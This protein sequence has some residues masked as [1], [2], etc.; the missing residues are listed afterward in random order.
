MAAADQQTTYNDFFN[1]TLELGGLVNARLRARGIA[2]AA[3]LQES[4]TFRRQLALLAEKFAKGATCGLT[5][6]RDTTP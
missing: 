2:P 5:F 4:E 3:A 1:A 6:R